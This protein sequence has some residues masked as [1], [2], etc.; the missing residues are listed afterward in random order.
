[1]NPSA[2]SELTQKRWLM[3]VSLAALDPNSRWFLCLGDEHYGWHIEAIEG[4]EAFVGAGG[5]CAA[6]YGTPT[7][8]GGVLIL[9]NNRR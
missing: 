1:M 8:A 4:L 6:I 9:S 3:R 5:T 2:L 7:D